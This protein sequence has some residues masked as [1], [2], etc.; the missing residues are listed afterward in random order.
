MVDFSNLTQAKPPIRPPWSTEARVR[1]NCTSCG[2]CLS[3][4]PEGILIAGR[5]GTP[6]VQLNGGY[7]S[8]CGKCADACVEGVFADRSEAPWALVAQIEIGCLLHQG[9]SC[10]SCT[11][12]CD[13]EAIRLDYRAGHVGAIEINA[14]ACTGCGACIG[15]CPTRAIS[16][17]P[18]TE[19]RPA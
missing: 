15:V 10:Q 3:A 8:F 9:V 14:A 19:G 16:L 17:S 2:D 5:A 7:C 12:A 11:D 6:F 4:C 13:D 1:E 18:L